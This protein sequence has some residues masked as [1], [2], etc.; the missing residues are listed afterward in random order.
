MDTVNICAPC[1][2]PYDSYGQIAC[3]LAWHL[4]ADY[5]VHVN[6]IAQGDVLYDTQSAA[7]Q[8]LLRQ[9]IRP[10]LGGIVLGYPTN[11]RRFGGMVMAGPRIAVTNWESTIPPEGWVDA[12]NQCVAVSVPSVF[13]RDVLVEAGTVAPVRIQPLGISETYH[14]VA[15]PAERRPFTF[16]TIGDR[17][18]RK[19][20]DVALKAFV[21]AFE[22]D[23]AYRLIV[24]ARRNNF[25]FD[26]KTENVEVL[27][28]DLS[29]HEMQALFERVDAFVF[30]TR[31][32]GFGLPPREAA[33]TGLPVICT[34]WSGTADE[35]RAWGYPLRATLADAWTYDEFRGKCG[36]WA[37]PDI[38]HLAEQMRYV[39]SG[40]PYIAGMAQHAARRVRKL[41]DWRRFAGQVLDLWRETAQERMAV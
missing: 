29:E 21:L 12:L 20:W 1:F 13:V 24:K 17:N 11:H 4:S 14:Y 35:L 3:R 37:E 6:A 39:A 28:E 38:E 19:G 18:M 10:A 16:L 5:G 41:Y 2:D 22:R 15:R 32:E 34:D 40:S 27:R 7:L 31:G 9:P 23:P 33:A 26:I 25:R 36:L 8:D 30:P